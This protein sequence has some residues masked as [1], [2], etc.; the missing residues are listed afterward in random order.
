[1]VAEAGGTPLEGIAGT[2]P[3][4]VTASGSDLP[5]S[6]VGSRGR[7]R[8]RGRG[9]RGRGCGSGR[10]R[11]LRH[12]IGVEGYC[13]QSG[14]SMAAP[15]LSQSLAYCE[16]VGTEGLLGRPMDE[17]EVPATGSAGV[18]RARSMARNMSVADPGGV[19]FSL[20]D[21][22]PRFAGIPVVDGDIQPYSMSR[23]HGRGRGRGRGSIR[24]RGGKSSGQGQVLTLFEGASTQQV[25]RGSDAGKGRGWQKRK[26]VSDRSVS[27][28]RVMPATLAHPAEQED[29]L[30]PPARDST[31]EGVWP[32]S[33]GRG[34][35]YEGPPQKR[36]K[37]VH[38]PSLSPENRTS[39]NLVPPQPL[40]EPLKAF[41]EHRTKLREVREQTTRDGLCMHPGEHTE[42]V[43]GDEFSF[44]KPAWPKAG[45]PVDRSDGVRYT[46]KRKQTSVARDPAKLTSALRASTSPNVPTGNG[47]ALGPN[48]I[49]QQPSGITDWSK[50]CNVPVNL[51]PHRTPTPESELLGSGAA[52]QEVQNLEPIP[53]PEGTV[54]KRK[55]GR[56]KGSGVKKSHARGA[57]SSQGGVRGRTVPPSLI[58]S[59]VG[60]SP[61]KQAGAGSDNGP[62]PC[63][64]SGM[65]L[66]DGAH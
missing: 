25:V 9:S 47:S 12:V 42:D 6:G 13:E 3:K 23:S 18:G 46:G 2:V 24:G 61:A 10:L 26:H 16:S 29:V 8:G 64:T 48:A 28:K 5:S 43:S 57:I 15:G 54:V 31:G 33:S 32:F 45:I 41:S 49:K 20:P 66:E 65:D 7:G 4:R 1:M 62:V 55:R 19:I 38:V 22:A 35:T 60:G 34:T 36:S 63:L 39:G 27:M 11:S 17:M 21:G 56:P 53:A 30:G 59:G 44:M 51:D 52:P 14:G 37:I 58:P 40:L 50:G